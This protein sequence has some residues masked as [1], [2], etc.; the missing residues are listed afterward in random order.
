MDTAQELKSQIDLAQSKGEPVPEGVAHQL[1]QG[2]MALVIKLLLLLFDSKNRWKKLVKEAKELYEN[3]KAEFETLKTQVEQLL[4]EIAA[5]K[6]QKVQGSNE[7]LL[8]RLAELE[9]R[10]TKVDEALEETK[11]SVANFIKGAQEQLDALPEKVT[12][13]IKEQAETLTTS[14]EELKTQVG[15]LSTSKTTKKK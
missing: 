14:I 1:L 6:E 12:A 7:A 11:V 2:G 15:E 4:A 5:L 10:Q 8:T 9:A 13:E 3:L